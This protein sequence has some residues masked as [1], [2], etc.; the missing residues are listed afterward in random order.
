MTSEFFKNKYLKTGI[1]Y[2]LWLF[3]VLIFFAPALF[4]N[5][6]IAPIDCIECIFRPFA[7]KPIEE[8]HN[9][10][11]ID[12]ASQYT[13]YNWAMKQSLE[14]D[15]YMGW[16]P[17][18]H[19]GTAAPEN[20]MLSP[21]DWHHWL[22]AFLPF[23]TAWDLGIILQF[24]IAGCGMILLLRYYK[25]PIWG[26]LLA[27]ISFAFFSQFIIWMYDRWLGGMIWTPFLIWA[28]LKNKDHILNIPA[29]IFMALIWRGGHMQSCAFAFFLVACIW[30]SQIWRIDG[31]WPNLKT[32]S[33]TTLSYFLIGAVGA[34]LSL[35]VFADTLPRMEGCKQVHFAWGV[36]NILTIVTSIFPNTLGIPQTIDIAK[37]FNSSLFDIKFGGGIV[38][39]LALIA[40]FNP[41]APRMAKFLFIISL[42]ATFTPL[43]TYLYSRSTVIMALGMAWL[44][45][46]QLYDLTQ[47]KLNPVYWKRITIITLSILAFWLITSAIIYSFEDSSYEILHKAM[48]NNA[49]SAHQ[50]GRIAWYELRIDKLLSQLLIWDWRNLVLVLSLI[51]GLFC[52]SKIQ[53][54]NQKNTVYIISILMFSFIDLLVFSHSWLSFGETPKSPYLY[55]CPTWMS[56]LQAHVKDGSLSIY[57]P[58]KDW[59][60]LCDNHLSSYNVRLSSGYETVQPKYLQP[61]NPISYSPEDYAQ[62]GISH[63]LADTKWQKP[64]FP[65]WELV[66]CEKD[67]NLYKN[68]AYK[69]RYFINHD[70]PI[71]ENW[72]TN[73]RIHLTIPS[74]SEN[75]TILES[76]HKGWKAYM[77]EKE[78]PIAPTER[79]GMQIELPNSP[80]CDSLLLEFHMPYREWYYPIMCGTLISLIIFGIKQRKSSF[81]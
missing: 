15:G 11:N 22:Y 3:I 76:Y 77:K 67:F 75:L 17:Y 46:Y 35:D 71:K 36:N 6:V 27:A 28:L 29:I 25:I 4:S 43:Y 16:N 58:K 44:A 5:K 12:G 33:Q 62:A 74:N 2:I 51:G 8:V 55:N 53:P 45:A 32:I 18:T 61:L 81:R 14:Q 38:F 20:T 49:T 40:C 37:S 60:F 7:Y 79:Y 59:D 72:R 80:H 65:E 34:L 41:R 69:G 19:N 56:K 23:W 21:G 39:I 47:I 70:Q 31:K 68:P 63:I 13:S 42:C 50:I 1:T 48:I 10:Y 30:A 78:L 57:N 9:Q 73:N 54:N 66:M 26:C 52:C 24:F 64:N